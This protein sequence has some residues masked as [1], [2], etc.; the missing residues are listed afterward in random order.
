MKIKILDRK[1]IDGQ[2]SW[3]LGKISL[4]DYLS[5]VEPNNYEFEVQRGIVK[6]RYLDSI[7][8]SIH[9]REVIPPITITTNELELAEDNYITIYWCPIKVFLLE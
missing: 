4:W 3:F 1:Q 2:Q 7:L 6:N 5:A 8:D 9:R